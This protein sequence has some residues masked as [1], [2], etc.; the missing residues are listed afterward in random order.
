MRAL[1]LVGADFSPT[2]GGVGEMLSGIV[3]EVTGRVVTSAID[4]DMTGSERQ[5]DLDARLIRQVPADLQ[6]GYLGLL[7]AG[8][9]GLPV[10]LVWWRR[11]WPPEQREG[12]A[13]GFGYH[14]ARLVRLV[15]F[16]LIFLPLAGAPA[17]ACNLVLQ[18]WNLL[19]APR[20]IWR[21]LSAP[22]AQARKLTSDAN[23]HS[24]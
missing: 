12:Y 9:M 21:R 11:L 16:V 8:L 4:A 15:C 1:P 3:S 5:R 2:S 23:A 13:G 6:F 7:L 24:A 20:R 14:A 19:V 18:A 17:F 22:A 10:A